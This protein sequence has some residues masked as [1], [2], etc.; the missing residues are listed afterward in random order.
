MN[1][2]TGSVLPAHSFFK[3]KLL[4]T[5]TPYLIHSIPCDTEPLPSRNS[6]TMVMRRHADLANVTIPV[7]E[8]VA[9]AEAAIGYGDISVTV[10]EYINWVEMS[11]KA[12][13]TSLEALKA[14]YAKKLKKNMDQSLDTIWRDQLQ[15]GTSVYFANNVANRLAV[16]TRVE[17]VDLYNIDRL[18]FANMAE[19]FEPM[20]TGSEKIGTTPLPPCYLCLCHGDVKRDL[21]ALTGFKP[22]ETYASQVRLYPSEFGSW[23][24]FR[25]I[26]SQ[27]CT[28]VANAGAAIGA[29]G[30][31]STGGVTIDVYPMLIFGKGAAKIVPLDELSVDYIESG[32]E[33]DRPA[34]QTMTMAWKSTT[35]VIIVQQAFMVRYETGATA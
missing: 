2:H 8:G 30:L 3:R 34:H 5:P 12:S 1:I 19:Y 23:G 10:Q 20:A 35:A 27:N 33:D 21:F 22:A 4:D 15:G 11:D 7:V 32:F 9:P 29:S 25:F 6:S 14:E 16:I 17:E 18:L 24:N 26:G 28:V 13:V 31:I